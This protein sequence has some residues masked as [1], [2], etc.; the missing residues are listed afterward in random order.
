MRLTLWASF[1]PPVGGATKSNERI[2]QFVRDSLSA[3][4]IVP[5]NSGDKFTAV[6]RGVFRPGYH[7]IASSQVK[8]LLVL[9][10][11][12]L[13]HPR[14]TILI[15]GTT[16][17]EYIFRP[18]LASRLVRT[19]LQRA[20]NVWVNNIELRS[21]LTAYGID[22][23][24]VSPWVTPSRIAAN[25]SRS[26]DGSPKAFLTTVY[27]PSHQIYHTHL[28]VTALAKYRDRHPRATLRILSYGGP[29]LEEPF[30]GWVTISHGADDRTVGDA[31]STSDVLIRATDRDGDSGIIREALAAG[32][33]VL[34][35]DAAPRPS[36]VRLFSLEHH[37]LVNALYGTCQVSTGEGL[38]DPVDVA[39][40]E[41][42]SQ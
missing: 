3:T 7:L 23:D 1:P 12:L 19:L 6:M 15:H 13:F 38:G 42:I 27:T 18:T 5:L 25:S 34:A 39:I 24:V 41:W 40:S 29:P 36:G 4:R 28:V 20:E 17:A 10:P 22:S 30:P 8:R 37:S 14:T 2:A 11:V 35:S 26:G 32:C 33:Q 31:L 16:G 9:A 21:Q